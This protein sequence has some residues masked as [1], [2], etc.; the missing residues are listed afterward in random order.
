MKAVPGL[1]IPQFIHSQFG[2][3][4]FVPPVM[5]KLFDFVFQVVQVKR[6][7]YRL[8]LH[9]ELLLFQAHWQNLKK[10]VSNSLQS[11]MRVSQI[12][13]LLF[14]LSLYYHISSLMGRSNILACLD[15]CK[16][17]GRC[18]VGANE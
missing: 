1:F 15:R 10:P 4:F 17:S 13:V 6:M 2:C 7:V 18:H 16:S 5:V 12:L 14:G 9:R 3:S 11:Q 8:S